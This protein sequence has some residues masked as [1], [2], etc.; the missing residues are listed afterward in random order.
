[1]SFKL[2]VPLTSILMIRFEQFALH[3]LNRSTIT[4]MHIWSWRTGDDHFTESVRLDAGG[5]L[6]LWTK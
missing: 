5:R 3:G 6:F 4:K 2:I 1:M